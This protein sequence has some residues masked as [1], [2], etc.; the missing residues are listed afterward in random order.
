MLTGVLL[1]RGKSLRHDGGNVQSETRELWRY[2]ADVNLIDLYFV[3]VTVP[4]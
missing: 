3:E 2:R 1:K 4:G